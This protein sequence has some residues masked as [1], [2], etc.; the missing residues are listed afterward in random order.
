VDYS[1]TPSGGYAAMPSGYAA[2]S[3][4]AGR[5]P[6]SPLR[7]VDRVLLLAL[8]GVLA[9]M[10][11]TAWRLTPSP[12]GLGTHQQLGLAPCTVEQWFGLR[13][14]SCGM[15]T[16][17][18]HVV[19]GQVLAACRANAGGTLLAV[20]ALGGTPWLI[21]SG[22]RGRWIVGRPSE[23]WLFAAALAIVV[24][25]LVQWAVRVSLGW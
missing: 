5:P 18:A 3:P 2:E 10:L 8:G 21:A 12:R 7:V 6:R 9:A 25:T 23:W 1:S 19:Q 17:W 22:A 13:C 4:F 15:T 20:F 14:P 11:A 24:I 16:A